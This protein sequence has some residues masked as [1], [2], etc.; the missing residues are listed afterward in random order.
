MLPPPEATCRDAIQCVTGCAASIPMP[1]PPEPDLSCFLECE[2]GLNGDEALALLRLTDCVAQRCAEK[3][4]CGGAST[5]TGSSSGTTG[6]TG[7]GGLD[8]CTDCILTSVLDP[9]PPGCLEEGE[10]CD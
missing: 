7:E 9:Q 8:P 4:R 2:T 3:G 10:A 6:T 5:D 1:L